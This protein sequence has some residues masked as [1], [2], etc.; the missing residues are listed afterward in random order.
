MQVITTHTNADLDGLAAMVAAQKI[1]PQARLVLSG[2]LEPTTSEFAALHRDALKLYKPGDLDLEKVDLLILVDTM[3]K[4]RLGQLLPVLNNPN[5]NIHIYDHHPRSEDDIKGHYEIVETVGATTTLFVEMIKE[6]QLSLNAFEATVLALGIYAD[7]GSLVFNSTT[8]RDVEAVAYLLGQKA[9]LGVIARFLGQALTPEQKELLKDLLLAARRHVING[10]RILI[11]S[12]GVEDFVSGLALLTHHLADMER[13]DAVFCVVKMD[14]RIHIVARSSV[15]EVNVKEILA[16]LGGGGHQYAASA[17]I[18]NGT[19]EDIN[20]SLLELIHKLTAPPLLAADIMTYPVRYLKPDTVITEANR[21]ML[22]YGYHGL[23]VVENGRLVGIV[24]RRDIGKALQNKL[25][26]APIKGFMSRNV[27]SISSNLSVTEV[28]NILI[29]NNIGRLPVLEEGKIIGIISR[30]DILKTMH[31]DYKANYS[32]LYNAIG[33]SV[34]ENIAPVLE[35]HLAPKDLEAVRFIGKKAM[36]RDLGAFLVGEVVRNIFLKKPVKNPEVY[37]TDK[38]ILENAIPE[39]RQQASDVQICELEPGVLETGS[40]AGSPAEIALK[41]ALYQ[42]DFTMD[43]MAMDLHPQHLGTVIDHFAGR[44]DLNQRVIRVL[45]SLS[46]EEQPQRLL[47]AVYWE[48]KLGFYLE[49]ETLELIRKGVQNNYLAQLSGPE[50]WKELRILLIDHNYV[51]IMHRLAHLNLWNL[52]FP[53]ISFWESEYMLAAL[54]L[55]AKKMKK[56]GLPVSSNY[57]MGRVLAIIHRSKPAEV[58]QLLRFYAIPRQY[59]IKIIAFLNRY[60]TIVEMLAGKSDMGK[61]E[62]AKLLLFMPRESYPFL[63][64][65]IKQERALIRLR[66]ALQHLH[67]YKP[68]IKVNDPVFNVHLKRKQKSSIIQKIWFAKLKGEIFSYSDEQAQVITILNRI[69]GRS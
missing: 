57:W 67:E 34:D 15:P 22:R 36:E 13:A 53:N 27:L 21:I 31:P 38:S 39:R 46:F 47:K 23:P 37:T 7:T 43:A 4:N 41:D 8:K 62:I 66:E 30:T 12:T 44:D 9:S 63:V 56:W 25:G 2:G 58:N 61:T 69:R 6:K 49:R 10:V 48:Q 14:N 35:Q 55:A 64:G 50:L 42:Q 68:Q 65:Y 24:S 29:K 59:R 54:P 52:I 3:Q 45:H 40:L 26:H 51:A 32:T 20:Q 19:I 60:P 1:Y 33:I 11:T 5:L 18:K 17:T 16:R 28:Q